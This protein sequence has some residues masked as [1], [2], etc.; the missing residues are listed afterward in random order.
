MSHE[1]TVPPLAQFFKVTHG[2]FNKVA[3]RSA[4]PPDV[5][6]TST[7][8]GSSELLDETLPYDQEE[9]ASV[10][11]PEDEVEAHSSDSDLP[12]VYYPGLMSVYGIRSKKYGIMGLLSRT[13]DYVKFLQCVSLYV[14]LS[15][16]LSFSMW[17]S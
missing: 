6:P 3:P 1:Q 7:V 14:G 13:S 4:L 11:L 17:G 2:R 9:E 5:E 8:H 16:G 12:I 10:L 15:V